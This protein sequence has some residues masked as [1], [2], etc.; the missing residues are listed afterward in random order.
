MHAVTLNVMQR[1]GKHVIQIQ[2]REVP[3]LL[4]A[5][6][7]IDDMGMTLT[8]HIS[9]SPLSILSRSRVAPSALFSDYRQEAHRR[10]REVMLHL[11]MEPEPGAHV[12]PAKGDSGRYDR[13]QAQKVV[14]HDLEAIPYARG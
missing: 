11:P 12:S 8:P 2:L 9:C 6:I 10:G 3:R 7:V 5:A 14:E 4:R 1:T 13:R